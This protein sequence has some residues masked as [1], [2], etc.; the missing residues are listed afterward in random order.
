MNLS[1]FGGALSFEAFDDESLTG[2]VTD[3]AQGRM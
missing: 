3:Q 2:M 1:M